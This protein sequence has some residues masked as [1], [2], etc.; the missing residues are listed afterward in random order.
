MS[1]SVIKE[2]CSCGA[3]VEIQTDFATAKRYV[4]SWRRNHTHDLQGLPRPTR[5][6]TPT[7]TFN[8]MTSTTTNTG[9]TSSVQDAPRS[10]TEEW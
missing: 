9:T 1:E 5:W 2:Y 7:Y 4:A 8:P 10:T 6:G 3:R